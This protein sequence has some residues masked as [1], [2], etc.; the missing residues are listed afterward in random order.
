MSDVFEGIEA[1]TV[2]LRDIQPACKSDSEVLRLKEAFYIPS[3]SQAAYA[4]PGTVSGI[5]F[6][7]H[8]P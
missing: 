2:H 7:N 3:V 4:I 5:V 6:S 1:V 8:D